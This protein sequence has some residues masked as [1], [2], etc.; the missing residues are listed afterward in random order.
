[1]AERLQR[2]TA[3]LI[4]VAGRPS[5]LFGTNLRHHHSNDAISGCHKSHRDVSM[6]VLHLHDKRCSL[7]IHE[8]LVMIVTSFAFRSPLRPFRGNFSVKCTFL[9]VLQFHSNLFSV[10]L[11]QRRLTLR[12]RCI[13][14]STSTPPRLC[15]FT[16]SHA[17]IRR[18]T[19]PPPHTP[20]HLRIHITSVNPHCH[21]FT[22]ALSFCLSTYLFSHLCTFASSHAQICRSHPH[23]HSFTSALSFYISFLLIFQ[24]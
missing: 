2:N 21:S 1:M 17:H 12:C 14:A 24:I 5:K 18:S 10:V 23:C 15:T 19:S 11:A 22:S 13:N 8:S 7:G 16:S 6:C 9:Y 20:T 4:Y 3:R